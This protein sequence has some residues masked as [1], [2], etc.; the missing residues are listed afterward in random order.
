MIDKIMKI[1]SPVAKAFTLLFVF[2]YGV[3]AVGAAIANDHADTVTTFLGQHATNVVYVDDSDV[4]DTDYF[5]SQ[6]KSVKE[7]RGA[8]IG[9]SQRVMEEGAVLL[10]NENNALPLAVGDKVSLFSVSS[11]KPV[12]S[13]Y[14]ESGKTDDVVSFKDGL[15]AAGLTVNAELYDWYAAS[16]YGRSRSTATRTSAT[17]TLSAKRPGAY[18]P[19]QRRQ[20][21]S[22]PLFSSFRGS[23]AR[24]PTYR[25]ATSEK[26]ILPIR[27]PSLT[28]KTATICSFPKRN[29]TFCKTSKRRRQKGR[30]PRSSLL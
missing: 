28:P 12:L 1:L 20:A 5:K 24:R 11:A 25:C 4:G 15:E 13:G 7:V 2:V 8:G 19:R 9:Y 17:S 30:S 16:D 18:C 26:G 6:Y 3:L 21:A 22:I 10:R 29:A 27:T 14:R 23:A